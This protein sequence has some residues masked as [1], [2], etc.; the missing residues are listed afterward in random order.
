LAGPKSRR[1]QL[2]TQRLLGKVP[3]WWAGFSK[4]EMASVQVP[5]SD[6]QDVRLSLTNGILLIDAELMEWVCP[7]VNGSSNTRWE[8]KIQRGHGA[9]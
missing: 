8:C 2:P 1:T 3:G 9:D 4:C 6:S 7:L 5:P